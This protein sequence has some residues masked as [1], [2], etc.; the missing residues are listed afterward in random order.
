MHPEVAIIG[1]GPA[2]IST[3]IQLKRFDIEPLLFEKHQLGGLLWNAHRVEN[4]PGFP[5]GIT[6]AELAKRLQD[7]LTSY[8][9]E[10]IFEKVNHVDY[11]RDRQ[12]FSLETGSG[13]YQADIVVAA[14][15]T[16]AETRGFP[17]SVPEELREFVVFEIYPL[18]EKKAAHIVIIG[19]GDIAFDY[20]LHLCKS[21]DH[22]VTII[23]RS[24][25]IKALPLLARRIGEKPGIRVISP[26]ILEKIQKGTSKNLALTIRK[27]QNQTID[28]E[29][30]YLV[31]AVGRLPQQNYYT[32]S[33]WEMEKELI[34]D[35]RLYLA[36][37]VKNGRFRQVAIAAGNGI[38]TAMEI[39]QQWILV[40][41]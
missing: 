37:D 32:P 9:V 15:G 17:E 7:H 31:G 25:K 6:G 16:R 24:K 38:E 4:Y 21:I 12:K 8:H 13:S 1:G 35:G 41:K 18:L 3:A 33:L 40:K 10:V 19:A 23:Q 22:S 27:N 11:N 14:A 2:G 29:A 36:G 30:D 39:Y 26:A 28:I 20:A 34:A 5:S